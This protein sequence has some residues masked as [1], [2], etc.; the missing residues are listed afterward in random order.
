MISQKQVTARRMSLVYGGVWALLAAIQVGIGFSTTGD[1][2]VNQ[3]MP[4][5][6]SSHGIISLLYGVV[7]PLFTFFGYRNFFA[8]IA[9]F[10]LWGAEGVLIIYGMVEFYRT[11]S[12]LTW[13]TNCTCNPDA[14]GTSI[15]TESFLLF[16][17]M[18]AL[19]VMFVYEYKKHCRHCHR[20]GSRVDPNGPTRS[21]ILVA[22]LR[23][24]LDARHNPPQQQR[25]IQVQQQPPIQVQQQ[26]PIH[27]QQQP[28]IFVQQQPPIPVQ[29]QPPIPV[30]QQP[31][32]PVLDPTAPPSYE[33]AMKN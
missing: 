33:E 13:C 19:V 3:R 32:I 30:Q 18:I 20:G 9:I 12:M 8:R 10:I 2:T 31:P 28:P 25:P 1:C 15:V 27:V 7:P 26:P 22:S 17:F 16:M 21:Q 29:Q 23:D 5:Y 11:N 14:L 24:A 4:I 6:L